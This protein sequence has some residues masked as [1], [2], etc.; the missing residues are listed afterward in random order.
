MLNCRPPQ[1]C[2]EIYW[3]S[4]RIQCSFFPNWYISTAEISGWFTKVV[5]LC[6]I[7]KHWI[8]TSYISQ[9]CL[10]PLSPSKCPV[11]WS[12]LWGKTIQRK[13]TG[14]R[15]F[16]ALEVCTFTKVCLLPTYLDLQYPMMPASLRRR[17]LSK[18][19]T[20]GL[21]FIRTRLIQNLG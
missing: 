10:L 11:R 3:S 6:P 1:T 8:F 15:T 9:T 19:N 20:S 4:N 21:R 5:F 14:I 17:I 13:L 12:C 2:T 16:W 18:I 7:Y